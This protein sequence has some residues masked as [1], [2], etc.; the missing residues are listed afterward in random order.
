[1]SFIKVVRMSDGAEQTFD[2]NSNHIELEEGGGE[3]VR[4]FGITA[5]VG[6]VYVVEV[7]GPDGEEEWQPEEVNV[8]FGDGV[9]KDFAGDCG[10]AVTVRL[11]APAGG[12]TQWAARMADNAAWRPCTGTTQRAPALFSYECEAESEQQQVQVVLS[13]DV[14]YYLPATVYISQDPPAPCSTPSH[15]G[16][17][18]PRAVWRYNQEGGELHPLS[19]GGPA[20]YNP[21]FSD[22]SWPSGPAPLAYVGFD[23]D[24]VGTFLAEPSWDARTT[25]YFRTTFS[26][27]NSAC[28]SSLLLQMPVNDGVIVYIN[29]REVLRLN[30]PQGDVTNA[31]SALA[32]KEAINDN[33]D[34]FIYTDKTVALPGAAAAPVLTDGVNVVAAEVHLN[35][36]DGWDIAWALRLSGLPSYVPQHMP[37]CGAWHV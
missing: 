16:L 35:H 25:Y 18:A 7:V 23:W 8:Y 3:A 6:E 14:N 15:C 17:L 33:D 11:K 22:S 21:N 27:T 24:K 10:G 5:L 29:N 20:F 12:D 2:G 30:M 19:P 13:G 9:N 26:L 37:V 36:D 1:M 32:D 34:G 4:V 28:F 31:T